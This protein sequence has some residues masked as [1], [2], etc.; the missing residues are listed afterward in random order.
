MRI[1]IARII[2]KRIPRSGWL[3]NGLAARPAARPFSVLARPPGVSVHPSVEDSN[4]QPFRSGGADAD[5]APSH[6]SAS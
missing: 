2:R 3:T 4:S 1:S 6:T 5:S